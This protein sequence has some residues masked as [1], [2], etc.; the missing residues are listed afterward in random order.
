MPNA[1][2]ACAHAGDL[3]VVVN[4]ARVRLER[5]HER[6]LPAVLVFGGN[7]AGEHEEFEDVRALAVRIETI[8]A[9][10]NAVGIGG[11]G[12]VDHVVVPGHFSLVPTGA[13]PHTSAQQQFWPCP[14]L[15]ALRPQLT[16]A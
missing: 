7:T 2:V 12:Q 1:S 16:I 9:G 5:V 10:E 8:R 11:V 14:I 4:P 6:A 3:A 13:P 15:A